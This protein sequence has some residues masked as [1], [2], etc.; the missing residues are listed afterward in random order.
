LNSQRNRKISW[1]WVEVLD[2]AKYVATRGNSLRKL[3]PTERKM[4]TLASN[5]AKR[6]LPKYCAE[7]DEISAITGAPWGDTPDL[8]ARKRRIL[9][10][11]WV[12]KTNW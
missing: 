4:K 11:Q 3:S 1:A 8:L 10:G 6:L 12:P 7:L 9:L 2:I 5:A